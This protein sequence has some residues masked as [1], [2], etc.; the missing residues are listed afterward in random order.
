M[1]KTIFLLLSLLSFNAFASGNMDTKTEKKERVALTAETKGEIV[2]LLE[3][4]EKLHGAFF[5]YNGVEVE[6]NAKSM[7]SK[8]EGISD[9][10]ISKLLG[11][12]KGKLSEIKAS[13][14]KDKNNEHYNLISMAL[15][16]IVNKYDVG[17][18]YNAYSCPMVKKKWVQNSSKMAKVHNPYAPEMPHCGSR[19]TNH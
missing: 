10:K 7:I 4:N 14:S 5:D 15:I 18:K 6:K 8:I 1:F 3:E 17:K 2:S 19:D 13:N 11:F 9:Q 16:Y 12:S